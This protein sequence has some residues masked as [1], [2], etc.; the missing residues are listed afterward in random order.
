MARYCSLAEQRDVYQPLMRVGGVA[1]DGTARQ[2][3]HRSRPGLK[4]R[5]AL[6]RRLNFP[7]IGSSR[8]GEEGVPLGHCPGGTLCHRHAQFNRLSRSGRERP[9]KRKVSTSAPRSLA[10]FPVMLLE[11]STVTSPLL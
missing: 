7:L 4:G 6:V 1:V 8:A 9:G 2:R 10:V 5:S 3:D 11:F